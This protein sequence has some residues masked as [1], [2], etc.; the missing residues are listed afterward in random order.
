[1]PSRNRKYFWFPA[2]ASKNSP[3]GCGAAGNQRVK[4]AFNQKG[5]P[6]TPTV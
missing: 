6:L 1:L 5:R 3:R 2:Y 4:T